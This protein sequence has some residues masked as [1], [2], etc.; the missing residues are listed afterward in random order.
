MRKRTRFLLVYFQILY[1]FRC[2]KTHTAVFI[3]YFVTQ[4]SHFIELLQTPPEVL[5]HAKQMVLFLYI[6]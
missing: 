3:K 1:S 5:P 2:K 6:H 4:E